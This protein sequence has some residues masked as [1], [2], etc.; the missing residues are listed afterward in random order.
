MRFN[1]SLVVVI[2]HGF[3]LFDSIMYNLGSTI[4]SYSINYFLGE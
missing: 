2:I 4:I 3:K 1:V